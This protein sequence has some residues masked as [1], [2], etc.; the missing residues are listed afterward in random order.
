MITKIGVTC[1]RNIKDPHIL[2]IPVKNHFIHIR[3]YLI[4]IPVLTV[5]R[6]HWA[7][8]NAYVIVILSA[9]QINLY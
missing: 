2:H 4:G 8:S 1:S 3:K 7:Y 5:G 9:L 6:T